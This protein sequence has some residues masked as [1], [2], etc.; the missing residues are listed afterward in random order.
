MFRLMVWRTAYRVPSCCASRSDI[1][2]IML[3]TTR[4]LRSKIVTNPKNT[5]AC[6]NI[7][8]TTSNLCTIDSSA[9]S[10]YQTTI[11]NVNSCL[12]KHMAYLSEH[13]C[14]LLLRFNERNSY[15][16]SLHY[17]AQKSV[18]TCQ[19]S[20]LR[21]ICAYWDHEIYPCA[22]M[23]IINIL[24]PAS[25]RTSVLTGSEGSNM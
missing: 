17:H 11:A 22:I 25:S 10:V 21:V 23:R 13:S 12:G 9:D 24:F 20:F 8:R 3:R 14:R 4:E 7:S 1:L 16:V 15:I 18:S 6:L 5:Y 2:V 19:G